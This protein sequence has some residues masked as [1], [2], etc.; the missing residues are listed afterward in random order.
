MNRGVR[1]RGTAHGNGSAGAS[2]KEA[3]FKNLSGPR[4]R[5]VDLAQEVNHG[6]I[7]NLE[8][9]NGEPILDP[10]P[11]VTRLYVFGKTNGPNAGREKDSFALKKKVAD[12]FEVF[13]H[14]RFLTIKELIIDNGL[15]VR[16]TV[17]GVARVCC[18]DRN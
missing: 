17:A 5:L 10:L 14:E 1:S 16:M 11:D 15:P 4:K 2:R 3:F 8:V 9:R 7:E 18:P 6:R 13:D 12:L